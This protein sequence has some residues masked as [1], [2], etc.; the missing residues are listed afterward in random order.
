M[1]EK[2]MI[3]NKHRSRHNE[4]VFDVAR[5]YSRS[6]FGECV[7]YKEYDWCNI[8]LWTK[9]TG[10]ADSEPRGGNVTPDFSALLHGLLHFLPILI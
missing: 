7:P 9:D 2:F 1:S 3:S 6:F 4:C 8:N 5:F 10:D